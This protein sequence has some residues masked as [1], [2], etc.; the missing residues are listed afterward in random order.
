M[1]T[2]YINKILSGEKSRMI[3]ALAANYN[4]DEVIKDSAIFLDELFKGYGFAIAKKM[5]TS[6]KL[7]D[8]EMA[9]EI[10]TKTITGTI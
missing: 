6:I 9:K 1:G 2:T 7:E 5:Y 8:V 4:K 3:M 10:I